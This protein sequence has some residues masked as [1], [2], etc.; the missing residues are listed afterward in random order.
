M[1]HG[2]VRAVAAAWCIGHL[3]LWGGAFAFAFGTPRL[4]G[5]A[6]SA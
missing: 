2:Q 3:V 6:A 5:A 4:D 1:T